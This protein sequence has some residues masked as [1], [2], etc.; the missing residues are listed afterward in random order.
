MTR[1][2]TSIKSLLRAASEGDLPTIR[3]AVE[4]GLDVNTSAPGGMTLL[5]SAV[6]NNR[7]ELVIYLLLHGARVGCCTSNGI[8]PLMWAARKGNHR[9]VKA[10]LLYGSS[11]HARDV[12]GRTPLMWSSTVE[13]AQL[14]L[15]RLDNLSIRDKAG[16][17]ALHH[18]KEGGFI[19][20][21]EYLE[22]ELQARNTNYGKRSLEYANRAVFS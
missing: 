12:S 13:V 8:V 10:L 21:A 18:A 17:T 3:E 1:N 2:I 5:L 16:M 4:R 9:M 15:G 7:Y 6:I 14:L 22:E 11:P 20:L 19:K